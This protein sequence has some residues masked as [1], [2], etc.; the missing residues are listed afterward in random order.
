[1]ECSRLMPVR[2]AFEVSNT[3]WKGA[4]AATCMELAVVDPTARAAP[5]RTAF[6]A[7]LAAPL[8]PLAVSFAAAAKKPVNELLLDAEVPG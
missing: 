5:E 8:T 1:M 2:I 6:P 3:G 7:A 4:F